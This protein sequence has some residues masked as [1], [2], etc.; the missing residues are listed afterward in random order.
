MEA[1][2][3]MNYDGG[4]FVKKAH[5][6]MLHTAYLGGPNGVLSRD[7][8]PNSYSSNLQIIYNILQGRQ[9]S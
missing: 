4:Q 7:K 5:N 8:Q 6:G 2:V 3:C 9:I 1:I